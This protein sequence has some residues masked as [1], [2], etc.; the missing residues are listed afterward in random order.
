MCWGGGSRRHLE[1]L[2][3]GPWPAHRL[4]RAVQHR[5]SGQ[6]TT[7]PTTPIALAYPDPSQAGVVGCDIQAIMRRAR[8]GHSPAPSNASNARKTGHARHGRNPL[9]H[10][11]ASAHKSTCTTAAAVASPQCPLAGVMLP[12]GWRGVRICREHCEY[13]L[14]WHTALSHR[15]AHPRRC[16]KYWTLPFRP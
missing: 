6:I 7:S 10:V 16:N 2:R 3:P 11:R 5:A 13:T 14:F 9:P 1:D 15:P 4:L 8:T 12:R